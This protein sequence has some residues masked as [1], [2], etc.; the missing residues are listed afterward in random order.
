MP[1]KMVAGAAFIVMLVMGA[2]CGKKDAG[3]SGQGASSSTNGSSVSTE[4]ITPPP[5]IVSQCTHPFFPIRT[6]YSVDYEATAGKALVSYTMRVKDVTADTSKLFFRFDNGITAE[7][8]FTCA[9]GQVMAG[10][11]VDFVSAW[12]N[13][14][15]QITVSNATGT[16]LPSDL[17]VGSAWENGFDVELMNAGLLAKGANTTS[18]VR[19]TITMKH[20]VLREESVTVKAGKYTAF[21]VQTTTSISIQTSA[22]AKAIPATTLT[23]TE[24]WARDAGMI[25]LTTKDA[26][27]KAYTMEAVSIV[28]PTN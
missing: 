11:M 9:N 20:R 16:Y 13:T 21:K 1:K 18:S 28:R 7:Q 6:G 26:A 25:K 3:T 10:G 8:D 22:G 27:N 14:S 2:G 5:V 17:K 12:A 23:S 19:A 24:W 4:V 15:S